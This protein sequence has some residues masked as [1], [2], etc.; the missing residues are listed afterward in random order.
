[1]TSA[2]R[3][4]PLRYPTFRHLVTAKTASTVGGWMQLVAAGWLTLKLT[5]S[6]ASVGVITI[7]GRGPGVVMSTYGGVLADR[8]DARRIGIAVSLLQTLAA[9]VLAV[10]AS[11]N[12]ISVAVIYAATLVTGVG[13]AMCAPLLQGI[14]SQSVPHGM[15]ADANA[16]NST[17]Y[18]TA[19]MIGPVAGGGLVAGLG[20]SWCFAINAASFL[21]V[22]ALF[23]SLPRDV[24]HRAHQTVGVR[25]ALH[26]A[27]LIPLIGGILGTIAAFSVLVAPVQELAPV[28]AREHGSGAHLVGFLLG[29][30]AL[31]GVLGSLLV[32]RVMADDLPRHYVLSAT[33]GLAGL[34]IVALGL[35]PDLVTAL[36]AMFVAGLFWDVYFVTA[37][38][39]LVTIS[40]HEVVGSETGLFYALTLGGLAVG[41]PLLGLLVDASSVSVALGVSGSLMLIFALW[42]ALRTRRHL[43]AEAA[44]HDSLVT[45]NVQ[46]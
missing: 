22:V 21:A 28:I 9:A 10:T 36:I 1:M 16:I 14:V 44:A 18:T 46:R 13:G 24:K 2:T 6:A 32:P 41:A 39:G 12:T 15:L 45:I 34:S 23:V 43:R 17:A 27:R 35:A 37:Q 20:A 25:T 40:P 5:G 31:G 29:A 42:R 33:C 4:A 11:A 7:V 19:R 38:T 30:L 26:Q 3:L 8:G